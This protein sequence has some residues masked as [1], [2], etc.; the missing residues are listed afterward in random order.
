MNISAIDN[1][2]KKYYLDM[3]KE[4]YDAVWVPESEILSTETLS[5]SAWRRFIEVRN[6]SAWA[7]RALMLKFTARFI[8]DTRIDINGTDREMTVLELLEL[9]KIFFV[10]AVVIAPEEIEPE[11]PQALMF[12]ELRNELKVALGGFDNFNYLTILARKGDLTEQEFISKSLPPQPPQ[13]RTILQQ[14]HSSHSGAPELEIKIPDNSNN[15]SFQTKPLFTAKPESP[16]D[17]K[18]LNLDDDKLLI[19]DDGEEPPSPNETGQKNVGGYT[20]LTMP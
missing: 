9:F 10:K 17:S 19:T 12:H 4:E 6:L 20:L 2:I 1:A 18:S 3:E 5:Q 15:I 16:I 14:L 11:L 8:G 13:M 7:L